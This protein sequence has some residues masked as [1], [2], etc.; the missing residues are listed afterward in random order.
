M[1]RFNV[2]IRFNARGVLERHARS[3]RK[4]QHD[5]DQQVIK[6]SNEFIPQDRGELM[7]SAIRSSTIGEGLVRWSTPYA[8]RLYYNPQ[9]NFSTDINPNAGGLWFETAKAAKLPVWVDMAKAAYRG[10]F[11]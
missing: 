10:E 6:D 1:I 4:A 8:R 11:G 5:L 9:Y 3:I 2:R 7:R